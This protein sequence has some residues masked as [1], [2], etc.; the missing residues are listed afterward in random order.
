MKKLR[1]F[2]NRIVAGV[3][4]RLIYD[5]LKSFFKDNDRAPN[6]PVGSANPREVL[7]RWTMLG[8]FCFRDNNEEF[9]SASSRAL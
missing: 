7:S 3:A 9:N 2:F 5:W 1:E 8:G 4:G 6:A